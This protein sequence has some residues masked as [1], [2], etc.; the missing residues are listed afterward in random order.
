MMGAHDRFQDR[1]DAG[2]QLAEELV[3]YR[4][5]PDVVVLGLPRGGVPVAFEVAQYLN[6]KLDLILVRKLG[7]P[8]Q[9]EL[10]M[11]A[12]ASGGASYLDYEMIRELGISREAVREVI[13]KETEELHR[14]EGAYWQDRRSLE[15]GGKIVIL[16][17][18][19]L[20]TGA[21]M[22]AAIR[23]VQSSNPKKVVVAVPVAALDP[24]RKIESSVDE[25]VCVIS[26]EY[27]NAVGHW[28]DTFG[29]TSDDEVCS[30]LSEAAF[31]LST[32]HDRNKF[33]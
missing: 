13:S 28:Y 31:G 16:V 19:G 10:A 1:A 24:K 20:A 18:D 23:A 33:V 26:P 17:D 9:P 14:R 3:A 27:F 21:S 4:N 12:I 2:R 8:Y 25:F 7:V 5:K 6:A 30:L 22:L 32:I 15:L 29:Q 11:G